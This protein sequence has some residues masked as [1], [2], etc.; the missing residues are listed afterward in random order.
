MSELT[1]YRQTTIGQ[2]LSE[3]IDELM[4]QMSEDLKENILKSFDKAM[5]DKFKEL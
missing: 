3:S 2:A 5:C 4:Y 1:I